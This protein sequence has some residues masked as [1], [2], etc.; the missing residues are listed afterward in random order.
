VEGPT[1]KLKIDAL[2]VANV[3]SLLGHLAFDKTYGGDDDF[4]DMV[5]VEDVSDHDRSPSRKGLFT[6]TLDF[7]EP[8][9]LRNSPA[10]M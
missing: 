5:L 9:M 10:V 2:S 4:A 3:G 1:D 6:P 7:L 8:R